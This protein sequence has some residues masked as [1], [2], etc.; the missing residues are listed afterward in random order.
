[1][2]EHLSRARGDEERRGFNGRSIGFLRLKCLAFL[3]PVAYRGRNR[4]HS[5][6]SDILFFFLANIGLH[7]SHGS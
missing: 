7:G 6:I 1:V 5:K 4:E 3:A 2:Y